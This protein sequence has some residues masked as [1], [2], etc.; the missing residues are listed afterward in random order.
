MMC[1]AIESLMMIG[2]MMM[3]WSSSSSYWGGTTWTGP[4]VGIRRDLEFIVGA[5]V[6]GHMAM[7]V[8]MMMVERSEI[9]GL[10]SVGTLLMMGGRRSEVVMVI[11]GHWLMVLMRLELIMVRWLVD[12]VMLLELIV[13]RFGTVVAGD[14]GNTGCGVLAGWVGVVSQMC[15]HL[16]RM[17][18]FAY[19]IKMKKNIV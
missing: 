14:T 12:L 16:W 4:C 19:K 18:V 13:V 15:D 5:C 1:R 17:F 3:V 2:S 9:A 10:R 8:M 7:M 6:S 11:E